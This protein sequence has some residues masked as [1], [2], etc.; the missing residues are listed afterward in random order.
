MG[1]LYVGAGELNNERFSKGI[2]FEANVSNA[3][4]LPVLF[5]PRGW[6]RPVFTWS[7]PII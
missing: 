5:R 2:A 6:P 3:R 1:P 4:A 7:I